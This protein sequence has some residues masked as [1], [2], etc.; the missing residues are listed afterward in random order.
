MHI[1]GRN[2]HMTL[3]W[4]LY[5]LLSKQTMYIVNKYIKTN[6]LKYKADRYKRR[7][8]DLLFLK[9]HTGLLV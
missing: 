9:M 6:I 7:E 5:T 1:A 3:S 2:T 8:H 4:N